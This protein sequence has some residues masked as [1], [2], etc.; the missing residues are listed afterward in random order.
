MTSATAIKALLGL[1]L[2]GRRLPA[3]SRSAL[4]GCG[5]MR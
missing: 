3:T 2:P 1:L 4:I 5:E